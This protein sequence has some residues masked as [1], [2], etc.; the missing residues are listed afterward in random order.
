[1]LRR[2]DSGYVLYRGGG[3]GGEAVEGAVLGG[4]SG[5]GHLALVVEHLVA[6]GGAGE[7]READL[8]AKQLGGQV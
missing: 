1:M 3:E 7:E 8:L 4:C 5:H 6:G 2:E